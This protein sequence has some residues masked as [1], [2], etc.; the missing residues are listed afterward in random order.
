M[1]NRLLILRNQDD[2]FVT[3]D[4]VV[5]DLFSGSAGVCQDRRGT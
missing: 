5:V 4:M 3:I 2:M 1:I